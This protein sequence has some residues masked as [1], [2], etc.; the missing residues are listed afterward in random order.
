MKIYVFD[1]VWENVLFL[2]V[3]GQFRVLW[4]KVTCISYYRLLN[5]VGFFCWCFWIFHAYLS[6]DLDQPGN[7][8]SKRTAVILTAHTCLLKKMQQ[9]WINSCVGKNFVF[10]EPATA[11]TREPLCIDQE[12]VIGKHGKTWCTSDV[13]HN[14]HSVI[15]EHRL[16]TV[17]VNTVC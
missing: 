6:N 7:L 4:G 13:L 16:L 8:H 9:S 14:T 1:L 12:R 5:V 2:F 11:W 15:R 10:P 17:Y 3:F